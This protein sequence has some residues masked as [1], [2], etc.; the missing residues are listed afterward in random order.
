MLYR[1]GKKFKAIVSGDAFD[2]ECKLNAA[3][4]GL[5][6][7]GIKYEL[8]FN[9]TMG[10]CAYIVYEERIEI[11]ETLKEEYER[12]GEKYVCIQCPFYV[13]PTDGRV[14][15]TRCPVCNKLVDRHTSC[16]DEFY[17]KLDKGEVKVVEVEV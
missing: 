17:N 2:F 15:N 13:R 3:L 4:D 14:K 8:T 6:S 9:H 1:N 10:F 7:K 16:C 11:P 5:N 12:A